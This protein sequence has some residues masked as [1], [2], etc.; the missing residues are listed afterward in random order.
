MATDRKPETSV[1]ARKGL[2]YTTM[3][4]FLTSIGSAVVLGFREI[5]NNLPQDTFI[6]TKLTSRQKIKHNHSFLKVV[7]LMLPCQPVYT[8]IMGPSTM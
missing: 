7:W 4:I 6:D 2:L 3:W 5:E 8:C 1:L